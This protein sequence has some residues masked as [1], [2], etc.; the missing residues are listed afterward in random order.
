M[1]LSTNSAKHVLAELKAFH[2]ED[3]EER[4]RSEGSEGPSRLIPRIPGPAWTAAVLMD[5]Q[6]HADRA[7]GND[8]SN[9]D[10]EVDTSSAAG[11]L[12]AVERNLDVP[13][14]CA[15]KQHAS[16]DC[17]E[18]LHGLAS[19]LPDRDP[20]EREKKRARGNAGFFYHVRDM[21][22]MLQRRSGESGK[23]YKARLWNAAREEWR[24]AWTETAVCFACAP[25]LA[26]YSYS[27]YKYNVFRY[28]NN[29]IILCLT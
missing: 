11:L 15:R 6:P 3:L 29:M 13:P 5:A 12:M 10:S 16:A 7:I 4:R 17:I 21:K 24:V 9:S 8:D 25:H 2:V 28:D 14:R 1:N 20:S 23:A 18:H 26:I 27:N 19:S 22:A